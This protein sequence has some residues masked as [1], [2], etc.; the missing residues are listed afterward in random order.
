MAQSE[1]SNSIVV[2]LLLLSL[3]FTG[4]FCT[5]Q[6]QGDANFGNNPSA[7]HYLSMKDNTRIYYELYG[8]GK[9]IVLLHGG[10]YGDISEYRRLIPELSK[11]FQVIAMDTRGHAKSEIGHQ[12]YTYSLLAED[13][14]SVIKQVTKDSVIVV[15]FS[16]GSMM[17]IALTVSHP[18]IV[19]KLVF[20]SGQ[21]ASN[22]N[23]PEAVAQIKQMTGETIE[24]QDPGFVQAR[25]KLM[26]EPQRWNDFFEYFKNAMVIE[27]V[28]KPEQLQ[29]VTCPVLIIGGD[30]DGIKAED[31]VA[32]YRLLPNSSLAIIPNS[33]HLVFVKRP[34]LME[35]LI[36][37][38][39]LQ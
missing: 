17:G 22:L 25:K 7:G 4:P 15:G 27:T 16:V 8:S 31:M 23:S 21:L 32:T 36:L 2:K 11:H 10:L 12:P 30:R 1:T 37:P 39:A 13:A 34:D 19:K 35:A 3:L 5:G 14:Y 38:F 9:P 33:G 24:K 6:Q 20:V 29:A 26:P 18:E 28:F